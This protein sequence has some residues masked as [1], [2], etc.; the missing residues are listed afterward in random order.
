M[1]N[2]EKAIVKN[3]FRLVM[4]LIHNE[5]E[6]AVLTAKNQNAPGY[7]HQQSADLQEKIERTLCD[8]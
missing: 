4:L 2:E 7:L 3:A 5:R 8:L 6:I 1:N